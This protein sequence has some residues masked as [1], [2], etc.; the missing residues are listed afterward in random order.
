KAIKGLKSK[1]RLVLSG[2][3][4]ENSVGDIWSQMHFVNP[5]LLGSYSYFQK[6]FVVPI[7]KK[8]DEE[9]AARLQAIINPFILRRTKDQVAKELPPK[10]EQ[11]VYC[12]MT[13]EQMMLYE[14]IKSE[15]RNALLDNQLQQNGQG[16]QIMLLQGLTKLRQIAN[17]PVMVRSEEHT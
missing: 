3:P 15:Y 16:N 2:T 14:R 11:T 9:K 6:E 7:E 4:I 8:K 10:T 5:G 13:E 12:E 1:H 17:H